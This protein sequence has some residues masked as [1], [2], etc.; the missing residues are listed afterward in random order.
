MKPISILFA[1]VLLFFTAE[2]Q[3]I[4][5]SVV[6]NNEGSQNVNFE[7][8]GKVGPNY[9]VFK[10]ITWRSVLQVFDKDMNELSNDRLKFLPD[11]VLNVDFVTYSDYFIMIYQY[12]KG[13]ILYCDAVKM[14]GFG[15]KIGEDYTID[16]TRIGLR[17]ANGVYSCTYSEDKS[18]IL[19]YKM[20]EKNNKLN[21]ATKLYNAD[22]LLLDSTRSVFDYNDR[23]EIYS[24]FQLA[25][26]GTFSFTRESKT[27]ARENFSMIELVEHKPQTADFVTTP[28]NL[29]N[30]YIDDVNVK[31]D[32]LNSNY[33]INALCYPEKKT[34][35]I[36]GL[37]TA[38]VDRQTGAVKSRIN[39]FS[40]SLRSAMTGN[41]QYRYAFDNIFL[42][43]LFL[44]R[45]GS[46]IAVAEDFST[47]SI[48]GYR[49]WNRWDY[50]YNNPYSYYDYNYMYSPYYRYN[51]FNSFNTAT[52]R[53][54]YDKLL[55]LSIDSSLQLGWNNVILKSQVADDD[56]SYLSFGTMNA[57]GQIHFFYI[58]KEKNA[59]I[60]SNQS[61]NPYG[62]LYRYP[63]IKGGESGYL[64]MPRLLKQVGART[65]IMPCVHR[66]SIAFAK[67]DL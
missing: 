64:F 50:L 30:Y 21:L 41:G 48:G 51:R 52:T 8:L 9:L 44:K 15:K 60:V 37:F 47:Q 5:Y 49:P 6:H 1:F 55:I 17:S 45:D 34:S 7:I 10:S 61:I 66:S 56:D 57:G 39:I 31:I 27:G 4:T 62:S 67:I 23:K 40:D 14:D 19:V 54:Y 29:D 65:I 33:L 18:R 24:A 28:I 12:Q 13:N 43:N 59:Q 20:I 26:D 36:T 16:T 46:F 32:N 11:K 2:A 63:T 38:V 22:L 25:N 58:E 35:N 42:K 3:K 53:Y